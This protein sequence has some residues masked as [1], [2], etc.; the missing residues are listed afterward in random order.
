LVLGTGL[1]NLDAMGTLI[2]AIKATSETYGHKNKSTSILL[3]QKHFIEHIAGVSKKYPREHGKIE[4]NSSLLI[5]RLN[6]QYRMSKI[7]L[8]TKKLGYVSVGVS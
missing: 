1:G 6:N 2:K 7:M 3:L 8:A 4:E 5:Q